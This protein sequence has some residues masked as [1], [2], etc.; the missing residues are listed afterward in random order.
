MGRFLE[1]EKQRQIA[2]KADSPT[3]SEAAQRDG[4]YRRRAR[5]FCLPVEHAEENLYPDIRASAL[6]YFKDKGILWHDGRNGKCSN[7]LCSSQ[8]CCVN[9]LFPL[10]D[11]PH[12]LAE[13][14]RPLYPGLRRMLPM[15][16]DLY[17]ALEWI[18]EE[19]YLGERVPRSG[20]RTRGANCTSADAAVMF[21]RDDGKRQIVL[22][23]WKYSESYSRTSLATS[24]SGTSRTAI[25]CPIFERADCPIDKELLPHFKDLF[26][27]PFYQLMRQQLLAHEMERANELGTDLV[28]VLHIAPE[29]NADFRRM[30]S[31]QLAGLGD[32]PTTIWSRL[33]RPRDRFLSVSTEAL[34]GAPVLRQLPGLESWLGYLDQRYAWVHEMT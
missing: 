18:G 15:E 20:I 29:H 27:E 28:S 24:K 19:N 12:A 5:P 8:V 13:L 25:Y 11:Q 30:T 6:D 1:I 3:L 26:Y 34:F 4:V 7:H 32:S 16:D 17:V 23:E 21:E 2:F 33:V 9:F 31:P 22:I 10:A 14:L